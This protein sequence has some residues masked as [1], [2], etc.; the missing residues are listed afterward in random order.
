MSEFGIKNMGFFSNVGG[1]SA[2]SGTSYG[3]FYDTTIQSATLINT[4]YPMKLNSSDSPSNSGVVVANDGQG[5]P[6]LITANVKGIYNLQ[7]SAQLQR[8]SGGQSETIDIWLRKNDS[9]SSGNLANT[10]T[11][12][13]VQSN[14]TF[15]VTAWNFFVSLN[16]GDYVQLMWSTTATTIQ[17]FYD[18]PNLVIP[19]PATPSLIVTMNKVS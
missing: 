1:N 12:V 19:H 6:T 2:I 8:S 10:N 18:V 3:S 5:N 16:A 4:P 7:F 11:H 13:S 14:S 15:L 17:L 9:G